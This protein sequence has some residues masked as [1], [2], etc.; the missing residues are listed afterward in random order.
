[1]GLRILQSSGQCRFSSGSQGVVLVVVVDNN[2]LDLSLWHFDARLQRGAGVWPLA[3]G[4]SCSTSSRRAPQTLNPKTLNPKGQKS[5][6]M[7]IDLCS[8]L[9]CCPA[10]R[11]ICL[12]RLPAGAAAKQYG[13]PL[14][15]WRPCLQSKRARCND[16]CHKSWLDTS[17]HEYCGGV[18]VDGAS[19]DNDICT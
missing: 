14:S 19:C 3:G 12:C 8:L 13:S 10:R 9:Q 18:E 2:L 6:L 17:Q 4:L 11:G 7:N 1:M 15:L 16:G 5:D